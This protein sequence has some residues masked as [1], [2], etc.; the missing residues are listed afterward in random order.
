MY[1]K[2]FVS[3]NLTT[4]LHAD[5]YA[6]DPSKLS[7]KAAF[8]KVWKLEQNG[9]SIIGGTFKGIQEKN[10][11][12]KQPRVPRLPKPKGQTVGSLRKGLTMWPEAISQSKSLVMTIPSHVASSLLRPLSILLTGGGC[13]CTITILLP[14][15][16]CSV[17]FKEAIQIEC[18]IDGELKGFGQLHPRSQGVETLGT[19]YSSSLFPNRAPAGRFLLLNYIGGSTNPGILSNKDGELVEVVDHDLRKMLINSNA[20]EPSVLGVRVWPQA[21]P[22]FLVDH[23]DLLDAAKSSLQG[24]GLQ[25]L[26]LGGN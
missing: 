18:L 21:I 10:K 4:L 14:T 17:H 11:A 5:V 24:N 7:M 26:F 22:Q 6:G 25:G 9:G 23:L 2:Q 8:G 12:P 19:I 13:R 16:C 15:S 20:K 1:L 3:H